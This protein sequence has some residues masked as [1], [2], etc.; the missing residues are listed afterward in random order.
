VKTTRVT[1]GDVVEIVWLD[2]CSSASLGANEAEVLIRRT[3]GYYVG[4]KKQKTGPRTQRVVVLAGTIDGPGVIDS[5]GY[6]AF[7]RQNVLEVR[8]LEK[9][10]ENVKAFRKYETPEAK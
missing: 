4:W 8:V 9:K 3:V 5:G 1:P 6:W 10:D 7:P 2:I